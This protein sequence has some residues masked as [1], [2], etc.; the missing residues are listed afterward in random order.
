MPMT[1]W[2]FMPFLFVILLMVLL[3]LS[4]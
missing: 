1:R 3:W 2:L 4:S